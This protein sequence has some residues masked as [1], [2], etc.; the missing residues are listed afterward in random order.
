MTVVVGN[1]D[2]KRRFISSHDLPLEQRFPVAIRRRLGAPLACASAGNGS[3]PRETFRLCLRK[4][5]CRVQFSKPFLQILPIYEFET[6][7]HERFMK[8]SSPTITGG[9]FRLFA[10]AQ[11]GVCTCPIVSCISRCDGQRRQGT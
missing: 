9:R 11:Y 2:D 1:I 8:G 6:G 5:A 3:T 4:L 7:R 10:I